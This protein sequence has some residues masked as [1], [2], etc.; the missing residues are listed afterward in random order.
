M[1]TRTSRFGEVIFVSRIFYLDSISLMYKS[2]Q[3]FYFLNNFLVSDIFT[4][5]CLLYLIFQM[6]SLKY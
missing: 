5:N 1:P 6:Y 4:S 3:V 2:I